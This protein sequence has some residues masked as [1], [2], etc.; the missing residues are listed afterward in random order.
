MATPAGTEKSAKRFQL[1]WLSGVS[2]ASVEPSSTSGDVV[3][4]HFL[5]GCMAALRL[6]SPRTSGTRPGLIPPRVRGGTGAEPV[7]VTLH[8]MYR[9]QLDFKGVSRTFPPFP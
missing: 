6:P 9:A 7:P 5:P 8:I 2:V 3:S 4:M 1:V